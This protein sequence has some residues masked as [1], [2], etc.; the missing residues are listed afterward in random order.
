M[1]IDEVTGV[2][3]LYAQENSVCPCILA[4]DI[5]PFA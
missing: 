4:Y 3:L 1:S 5:W 2:H